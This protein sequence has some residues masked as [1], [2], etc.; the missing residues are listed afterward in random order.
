MIWMTH[1]E[2]SGQDSGVGVMPLHTC[3]FHT[4]IEHIS[5]TFK[6]AQICGSQRAHRTE[7]VV[8]IGHH[9]PTASPLPLVPPGFACLGTPPKY[10]YATCSLCASVSLRFI[11]A[12]ICLSTLFLSVAEE[13]STTYAHCILI[14]HASVDGC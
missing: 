12:A 1:K 7:N 9:S 6:N 2:P 11:C 13:Y 8:P 14:I 4:K 5:L 10:D 3:Y